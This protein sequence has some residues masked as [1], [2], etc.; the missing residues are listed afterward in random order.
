MVDGLLE[1][2]LLKGMLARL[3]LVDFHSQAGFRERQP[4]AILTTSNRHGT[5]PSISS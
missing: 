5:S 4:V 2:F 3:R 1:E